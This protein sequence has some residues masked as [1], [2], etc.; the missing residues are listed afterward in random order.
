MITGSEYEEGEIGVKP[1][2][3]SQHLY[4]NGFNPDQQEYGIV[5]K[6]TLEKK[7]VSKTTV[8][9]VRGFAQ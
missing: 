9:T 8:R 1:L 4:K 2:F 3:H 5:S 7:L 6:L